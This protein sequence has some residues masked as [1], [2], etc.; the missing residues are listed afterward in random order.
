VKRGVVLIYLDVETYSP[1][2]EPSFKDKAILICYKE[3]D[4]PALVWKEWEDGEKV[5]LQKF[6]SKLT[7]KL[8]TEKAVTLIGW[9]IV[10]FDVPFLTYRLFHHGVDRLENVLENFRKAYWRDLRLCLLPF[11]NYRFKGLKIDE[12]VKRFKLQP[13]KYSGEEIRGFYDDGEY[14]KIVEHALSEA[15]LLS[16]L[17][18]RM[19]NVEEV[20]KAFGNSLKRRERFTRL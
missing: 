10:R 9:N 11:N 7:G 20:M 3:V 5:V 2:E 1:G 18:R 15:E 16:A 13:P 14:E 8:K 19:M 4:G 6:Y 17:N 12:V